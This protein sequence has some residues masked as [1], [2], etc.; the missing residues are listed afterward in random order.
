[1]AEASRFRDVHPSHAVA[2]G[3][4]D[5]DSDARTVDLTRQGLVALGLALAIA[6][7][8][9]RHCCYAGRAG[10]PARSETPCATWVAGT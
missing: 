6:S 10:S 4:S 8:S 5:R 9:D 1:M 7:V 2:Y 3:W